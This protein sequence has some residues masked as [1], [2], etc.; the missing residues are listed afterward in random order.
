MCREMDMCIMIVILG[1]TWKKIDKLVSFFVHSHTNSTLILTSATIMQF[2]YTYLFLLIQV[3][4]LNRIRWQKMLLQ[5]YQ[6]TPTARFEVIWI[7][8]PIEILQVLSR[9][10]RNLSLQV[11]TRSFLKEGWCLHPHL[12]G[13]MFI[14]LV[15]WEDN[16]WKKCPRH[17]T[18]MIFPFNKWN[19][20]K[21]LFY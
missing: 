13:C 17:P 4:S 5:I 10:S 19:G 12:L 15:L 20:K 2:Y 6:L 9:L 7:T 18:R 3:I 21:Q 1:C 16:Q 14:I 11:Q 8:Y